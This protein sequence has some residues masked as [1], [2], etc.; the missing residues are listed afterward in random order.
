MKNRGTHYIVKIQ[1][2]KRYLNYDFYQEFRSCKV[3]YTPSQLR[4]FYLFLVHQLSLYKALY[5]ALQHNMKT[6]DILSIFIY[7]G[8]FIDNFNVKKTFI[9][10]TNCKIIIIVPKKKQT[11]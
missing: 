1:L 6:N 4:I 9:W 7:L 8:Q 11:L 10:I 2:K 3:L 5:D